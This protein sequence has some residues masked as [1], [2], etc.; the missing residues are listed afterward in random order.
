MFAAR[1]DKILGATRKLTIEPLEQ[2]TDPDSGYKYVKRVSIKV[3][4]PDISFNGIFSV[5]KTIETMDI[6]KWLPAYARKLAATFFKRPVYFRFLGIV[7]GQ[8]KTK[9]GNFT[10]RQ[11]ATSEMNFTQ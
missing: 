6:F 9:E 4:S 1:K 3:D 7:E 5:A 2:L 8:L 10:I 11:R